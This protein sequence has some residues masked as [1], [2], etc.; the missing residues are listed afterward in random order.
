MFKN[1]FTAPTV[2]SLHGTPWTL[3]DAQGNVRHPVSD[4][5]NVTDQIDDML[6]TGAVTI[7]HETTEI[8]ASDYRTALRFVLDHI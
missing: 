6:E 5:E 7:A 1:L 3:T 8:T 2:T 4:F